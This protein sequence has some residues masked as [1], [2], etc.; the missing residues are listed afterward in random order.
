MSISK[1]HYL[2]SISKRGVSKFQDNKKKSTFSIRYGL[3]LHEFK[4]NLWLS[5]NLDSCQKYHFFEILGQK[6]HN[7][8]HSHQNF[9]NNPFFFFSGKVGQANDCKVLKYKLE[10]FQKPFP[11]SRQ[12]LPLFLIIT[13]KQKPSKKH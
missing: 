4:P 5:C 9:R 6:N 2:T 8:R 11:L 1:I 3:S 13:C 7:L 12:S 10:A